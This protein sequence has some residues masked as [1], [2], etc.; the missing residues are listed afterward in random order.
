MRMISYAQNGEDVL[1]DRAFPRGV[2]GTYIDVGA[3]DP[4]V[5]SVTKHFYD[6]GAGL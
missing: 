1:L 5:N 4:V 3:F 2:P 6:L